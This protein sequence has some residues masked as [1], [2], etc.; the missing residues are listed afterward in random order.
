MQYWTTEE[1]EFLKQRLELNT[2]DLFAAFQDEYGSGYRTYDSVQ[3][4]IK[5]L[6]DAFSDEPDER[7]TYN[8]WYNTTDE[9]P[10]YVSICDSQLWL[11]EHKNTFLAD[12]TGKRKRDFDTEVHQWMTAV[13][14]HSKS[15]EYTPTEPVDSCGTTLM[16]LLSDLHFGKKTEYFNLEVAKERLDD[17]AEQLYQKSTL[18]N[19][20]EVVIMLGGDNVEGED[21]HATQNGHIEVPALIQTTKCAEALWNFILRIRRSFNVP[22]RVE[23]VFGNHGRMSKTANEQ[24]NWDNMVAYMLHSWSKM[25]DDNDIG[26][27]LNYQER[28]YFEVKDK[29]GMLTHKGPPHSGTPAMKIKVAGWDKRKPFDFVCHGHWHSW[30]VGNWMGVHIISNGCL[31][32]P[33]D[34]AARMGKENNANQAYFFVTPGE[35]VW[36]FSYIEWEDEV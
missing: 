26:I 13:I 5:K 35:P 19:I 16:I 21:I 17:M 27:N 29:V 12:L 31:P 14:N 7:E 23:T 28:V 18:V 32:G 20:D 2:S 36:G 15:F 3:K 24:S 1:I 9:E 34:L 8:L 6:R 25:Y 22:V 30:Q 10:E 33:D 4:K 11:D